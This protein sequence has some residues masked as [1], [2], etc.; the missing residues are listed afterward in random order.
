MNG[1]TNI[2]D[3]RAG[4][5]LVLPTGTSTNQ[6]QFGTGGPVIVTRPFQY[7]VQPGEYLELLALRYGTSV[8][9]IAQANNLS[10]P[11]RIFPGQVLIIP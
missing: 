7:I 4:Q 6:P 5:V 1:I 10:N 8:Q 3:V 9:A 2:N 11:S